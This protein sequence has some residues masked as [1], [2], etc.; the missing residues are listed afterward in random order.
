MAVMAGNYN[1]TSYGASNFDPWDI[2]DS[3][4]SFQL[5]ADQQCNAYRSWN[6]WMQDFRTSTIARYD[7]VAIGGVP[8]MCYTGTEVPA[9]PTKPFQ[10]K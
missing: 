1:Q 5:G 7:T 6:G 10:T 9:L 3:S 4:A 8:T 2:L